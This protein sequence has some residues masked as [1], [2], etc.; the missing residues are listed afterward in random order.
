MATCATCGNTLESADGPAAAGRA[1][2]AEGAVRCPA[3]GADLPPREAEPASNDVPAP[4]QPTS[5]QS[6][7]AQLGR[8]K[9]DGGAVAD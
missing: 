7:V 3:C 1:G 2:A 8:W 9:D 4:G 6:K 5:G